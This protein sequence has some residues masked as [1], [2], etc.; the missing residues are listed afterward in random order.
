MSTALHYALTLD[1]AWAAARDGDLERAARLLD[2]IAPTIAVLDLRARIHAQR[3][4]L[5]R[6]DACWAQVQRLDPQHEPARRGRAAIAAHRYRRPAM[7][8]AAVLVL[9]ALVA[10]GVVWL[11]APA[12]APLPAAAPPEAPVPA[13]A[14]T[15]IDPEVQRVR[16]QMDE[17]AASAALH[18]QRLS[19]IAAALAMPGLVTEPRDDDVR[20]VFDLGLF[21]G[22][23]RLAEGAFTTVTAVGRRLPDLRVTATVVGHSV[24]VAGERNSGGT[25]TAYA[26]AQVAAGLLSEASGL[27]LTAFTLATADQSQGPH[28]ETARNRTVTLLVRP[29]PA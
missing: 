14:P 2:P 9:V 18:R 28:P 6:A 13:A 23:T 3:G 27:P 8:G 1:R 24:P 20:V 4:D 26:R 25:T 16:Q 21:T 7:A 19:E 10:G 17:L 22:D 5:A 15:T 12:E 11:P 29:V